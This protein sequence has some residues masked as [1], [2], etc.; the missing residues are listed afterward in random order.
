MTVRVR[1]TRDPAV[2]PSIKGVGDPD[3]AGATARVGPLLGAWVSIH[4]WAVVIEKNVG[5]ECG[6]G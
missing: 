6:D 2:A 5:Y 4:H 1:E 3:Q